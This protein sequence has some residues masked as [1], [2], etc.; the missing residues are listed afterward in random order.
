VG[1]IFFRPLVPERRSRQPPPLSKRDA[2]EL[3]LGGRRSSNEIHSAGRPHRPSTKKILSF[4]R[5]TLAAILCEI[6]GDFVQMRPALDRR[7]SLVGQI[8]NRVGRQNHDATA[9]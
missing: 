4:F 8:R 7:G 9:L 6:S 2:Q 5:D 3:G 1:S